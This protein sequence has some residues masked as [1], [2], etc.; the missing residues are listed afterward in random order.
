M[1]QDL[2]ETVRRKYGEA[3]LRAQS[4]AEGGVLRHLMWVRRD[5]GRWRLLRPD[6]A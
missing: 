2:K 5:Q 3:A 6:H 1:S 4:G